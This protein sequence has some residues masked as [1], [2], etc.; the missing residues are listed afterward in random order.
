MPG[1]TPRAEPTSRK[2]E[3]K[4]R[5][6][7]AAIACIERDG[8]E[9]ASVRAIA[10]EAGANVAAV[11]YYFGSKGEL[12]ARVREHTLRGAL[13]QE[14]DRLD[15]LVTGGLPIRRAL[16]QW[17]DGYLSEAV[18]WPRITF[19]QLRDA[20]VEQDYR[21][22][23]VR[24]LN[25]FLEQLLGRLPPASTPL[26]GRRRRVVLAQAWSNVILLMLMPRLTAAFTQL[27]LGDTGD[28]RR[29]VRALLAP[30]LGH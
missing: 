1:K 26:A 23:A 29:Y 6:L 4:E 22:M 8:L 21:S 25:G 3:A 15:A 9:R 30:L 2:A 17:L 12:I 16:P 11:N 19:A 20:M 28:R 24:E 5:I 10:R 18:R 14:L 7:R 27:D 13:S